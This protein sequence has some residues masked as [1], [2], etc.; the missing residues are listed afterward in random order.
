MSLY[1]EYVNYFKYLCTQH[2][3]IQHAEAQHQDAFAVID[4]EELGEFRTKIKTKDLVFR[5]INYT[6]RVGQNST[7]QEYKQLQGGF[8][9]LDYFS[10]R[11]EG[12]D[13]LQAALDRSEGVADQ[14]I[15]RMILDSRE[16]ITLFSHSLDSQ[17]NFTIETAIGVSSDGSYAGWLILFDFDYFFT[18]CAD[19]R[20]GWLDGAVTP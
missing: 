7:G 18:V 2:P 4:I 6:N 8:M 9:I 1:A 16:G 3:L 20:A 17:Q 11:K 5:L 13:G 12:A 10:I 15:E 19:N 14:F